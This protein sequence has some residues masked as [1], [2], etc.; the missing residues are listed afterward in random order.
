MAD[1]RQHRYRIYIHPTFPLLPNGGNRLAAMLSHCP[2]GLVEAF[3]DALHAAVHSLLPAG[4]ASEP[5]WSPTK[6]VNFALQSQ[7]ESV[8]T[9]SFT[10][11]LILLQSL[12]FLAIDSSSRAPTQSRAHTGGSEAVWLGIAVGLA[13]SMRLHV[14]T[15][16]EKSS[17]S[18]ADPDSDDKLARRTWLTLIVMD[19]WHSA[20]AAKPLLIPDSSVVLHPDDKILLG[21]NVYEITRRYSRLLIPHKFSLFR[22]LNHPRAHRRAQ[23]YE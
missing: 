19:R 13:Y 5:Y 7:L 4:M 6:A 15:D 20:S 23:S 9:R 17:G 14:R 11:N 21:E 8:S 18:E 2:P 22:S 10:A 16:L 1:A 12:I 3:D